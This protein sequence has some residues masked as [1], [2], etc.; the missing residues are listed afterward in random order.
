MAWMRDEYEQIAGQQAPGAITGKP[1][2]L[3]GSEGRDSATSLGG[4]EIL[5]AVVENDDLGDGLDVAIQGFG[6]V[7]SHLA[8]FLHDRSYNV[9]AAS[10]AAGGIYDETGLPI[11]EVIEGY[12]TEQDL[13]DVD[14]AEISNDELLTLDVDVLVPAAIEDQI[15]ESNMADI[16]ADVVLEMANG[17][18]TPRADQY[19]SE[20]GVQIIPDILANAGGVTVSYF[21]WVQNTSNEYWTESTVQE[22]LRAQMR[23][24]FDSVAARK[25]EDDREKTW[26][27]AAYAKAVD[28]VLTA[29]EYRSNMPTE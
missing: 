10:N 5:D 22:K 21:E 24:A 2:A 20:Q 25:T 11:P 29:E 18:T 27:E 26:R 8:R 9:V 23:T 28:A 19:L 7:G 12:E 14:A 16:R 3:D 15:T 17:P 1:P 4:A 6:N 13:F